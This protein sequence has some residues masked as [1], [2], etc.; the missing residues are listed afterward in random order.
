MQISAATPTAGARRWPRAA[1]GRRVV[2]PRVGEPEGLPQPLQ[3][4]VITNDQ[5]PW[6][7]RTWRGPDRSPRRRSM[8]DTPSRRAIFRVQPWRAGETLRGSGSAWPVSHRRRPA[9]DV[10]TS[11]WF[12]A[13]RRDGGSFDAGIQFALERM[14][15]DPDFLLRVHRESGSLSPVVSQPS[16]GPRPSTRLSD[17][18]LASRLSFFLWSSVPDDRLLAVAERGELANRAALEKEVRR[19]LADP[20]AA[21]ALV[22]GFAAQWLNL[23]R[24][25]EVVVDPSANPNTT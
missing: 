24:V 16:P 25:D 7:T 2:R 19:M 11:S 13:G 1:R 17:I 5:V 9:A 6:I 15:V 20:R 12:R 18:E 10:E 21:D 3:R 23:R 22:D 4:L 14:L 8:A